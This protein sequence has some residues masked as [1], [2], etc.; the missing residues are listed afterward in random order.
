[1]SAFEQDIFLSYRQSDNQGDGSGG[2]VSRFHESLRIRLTEMMGYE[3]RIW[4]D[5][6]L[7]GGE[8]F[9][10]EIKDQLAK[11]KV[12]VAI[13]SPGYIKSPWC[14]GELREFCRQAEH[15]RGL[16]V[17]NKSRLVKVVKTILPRDQHPPQ[18][19]GLLGYELYSNED[20][21]GLH[22]EYGQGANEYEHERYTGKLEEIAS[23]LKQL[24]ELLDTSESPESVRTVYVAETT[25]D[26]Q[27]A[28]DNIVAELQARKFTVLPKRGGTFLR[29]IKDYRDSVRDDLR[30]SRLSVHIVGAYYGTILEGG[31]KSIVDL[32]NE[33]AAELSDEARITRLVWI[34]PNLVPQEKRQTDFLDYLRS[35]P[36]AQRGAQLFE[37]SFEELKTRILQI[38]TGAPAELPD[39]DLINVYLMCHELDSDTVTAVANYLFDKKYEVILP[40]N[41]TGGGRVL[42]LHKQALLHC[43]ATLI[44][45]GNADEFWFC[46]KQLDLIKARGWGRKSPMLCKAIFITD[47]QTPHKRRLLTLAAVPL[48]PFFKGIPPESLEV[49]LRPFVDAI[50]KARSKSPR[51]GGQ[52]HD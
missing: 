2:W 37:R 43:D 6:R 50:E 32:Q 49:S 27:H 17:G 45:Y 10:D 18:L 30:K 1:M 41:D 47:P 20:A 3:P 13:L 38:I 15:G 8:Y 16:R 26:L 31:D 46:S 5:N 7:Q 44:Y 4:R 22:R 34:A 51:G 12:L 42:R 23:Y 35:S 28:R 25:S 33:L 14:V 11:T 9:A 48:P 29:N 39:D 52:V 40:P 21:S 24:I 36:D 19:Q